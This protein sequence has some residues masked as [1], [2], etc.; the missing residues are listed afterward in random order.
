M[1]NADSEHRWSRGNE[2]PQLTSGTLEDLWNSVS[3]SPLEGLVVQLREPT[4]RRRSRKGAGVFLTVLV[5]L[6]LATMA[7]IVYLAR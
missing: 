5:L 1:T 7:A 4:H 2:T 6:V 3:G